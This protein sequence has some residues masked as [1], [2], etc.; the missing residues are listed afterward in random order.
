MF[1]E[2]QQIEHPDHYNW[3][4][5][6]ECVDVAQHFSFNLGNTI[7]HIWRSGKKPGISAI[8]DL[9]K[10]RY[11]INLEIDRLRK[12][13]EQIIEQTDRHLN[14]YRNPSGSAAIISSW[15]ANSED[16][17]IKRE[18]GIAPSIVADL[19]DEEMEENID[20]LRELGFEV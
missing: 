15:F 7:K 6:I 9:E 18:Y 8:S 3:I 19:N 20:A 10:A 16:K 17:V 11:Y 1:E 12:E 4:S 5:G 2:D 14:Y 13:K